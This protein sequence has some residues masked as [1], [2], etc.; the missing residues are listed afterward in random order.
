[1][2]TLLTTLISALLPVGIESIKQV[3]T[4]KLGGVKATTIDE[5]IRLDQNE[6]QKLEAIA[7]LDNPGGTPSQWVIDLRASS[8]YIAAIVVI[9]FGIVSLCLPMDTAVKALTFEAANIAFGFL[10]GTRMVIGRFKK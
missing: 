4:T 8:R 10:F 9:A 5:Q 3:V 1:M 6:I 2:S 7:A